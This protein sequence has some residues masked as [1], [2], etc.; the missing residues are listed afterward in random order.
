MTK[1]IVFPED[2]IFRQETSVSFDDIE[3]FLLAHQKAEEAGA[4][5]G[6]Y[7]LA[8]SFDNMN[9]FENFVSALKDCLDLGEK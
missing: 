6:K 7:D 5:F 8:V 4:N 9:Q 1:I 2:R 3:R